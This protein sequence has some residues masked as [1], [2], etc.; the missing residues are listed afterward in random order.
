M[1]EESSLLRRDGSEIGFVP[2]MGAL[3][4]GHI[5]LIKKAASQCDSVV[6]SIFVNPIQFGPKED[7]AKYPRKIREDKEKLASAGCTILFLPSVED[8]YR[9]RM[10]SVHVSGITEKLCG[11]S[12]PG[13]FDGVATVVAKLFNIVRPDRAYFGEKDFQQL[14]VIKKM[15]EDLNFRIKIVSCPTVRE[16][17]GLA[18]SSR[19]AYLSKDERRRAPEIYRTLRMGAKMLKDGATP[20]KVREELKMR[21][22]MIEGS[23]TDYLEILD[24][25]NLGEIRASTKRAR[26][27]SAVYMGSTRLIDNVGVKLR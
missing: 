13:H 14:A 10:T 18:M 4:E 5:S 6:A 15:N 17:D 9:E 23:R 26:I 1:A 8:M 7:L 3:H 2:T 22:E 19:N 12:R 24:E 25:E 20:V 16:K 27:F 21:I 11:V